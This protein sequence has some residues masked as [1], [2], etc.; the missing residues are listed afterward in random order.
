LSF[1]VI[2]SANNITLCASSPLTIA[3]GDVLNLYLFK[4]PS[5]PGQVF[6]SGGLNGV[7]IS[8]V[9][10]TTNLDLEHQFYYT[11]YNGT[12]SITRSKVNSIEQ[13]GSIKLVDNHTYGLRIGEEKKDY[14]TVDTLNDSM[15]LQNLTDINAGSISFNN[16][17]IVITKE[18]VG[19]QESM[20]PYD[21]VVQLS[22][23]SSLSGE[24]LTIS[25][26]ESNITIPITPAFTV[27][28]KF[29]LNLNIDKKTTI[30]AVILYRGW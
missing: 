29:E 1:G 5:P 6:V 4:T 13:K 25:A 20:I 10:L 15:T 7:S 17:E 8:G 22:N 12:C 30:G 23:F 3:P 28:D 2:D 19:S 11:G 27:G 18:I 14:L 24:I 16:N 9:Q 26:D 21:A